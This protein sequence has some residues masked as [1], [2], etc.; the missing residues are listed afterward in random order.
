MRL[1]VKLFFRDSGRRVGL[2]IRCDKTLQTGKCDF[3]IH[4]VLI[5]L[6][7]L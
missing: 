2:Y 7:D 1:V 5:I 4:L 6:D 3:L